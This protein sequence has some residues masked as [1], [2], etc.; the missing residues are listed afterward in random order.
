ML[1]GL[2]P[3]PS[4]SHPQKGPRVVR[5]LCLLPGLS[6]DAPEP[7]PE[8]WV[9]SSS[10]CCIVGGRPATFRLTSLRFWDSLVW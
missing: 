8:V 4:G 6:P 7:V 3:L 9:D 5:N 1:A 10:R 2:K